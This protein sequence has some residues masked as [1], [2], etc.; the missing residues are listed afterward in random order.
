[1]LKYL[2][3]LEAKTLNK[4]TKNCLIYLIFTLLDGI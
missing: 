1:M 2:G 4:S 3:L